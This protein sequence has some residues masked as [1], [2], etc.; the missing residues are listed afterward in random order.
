MSSSAT[1]RLAADAERE[2]SPSWKLH[3]AAGGMKLRQAAGGN[4]NALHLHAGNMAARLENLNPPLTCMDG[5]ADG[6]K[7]GKICHTDRVG[8]NAPPPRTIAV[9]AH[10]FLGPFLSTAAELKQEGE[11]VPHL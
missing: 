8:F 11:H 6:M 5:G 7:G 9:Y 10:R 3:G 1:R 2:A 4:V